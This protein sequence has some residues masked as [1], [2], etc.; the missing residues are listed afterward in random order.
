MKQRGIFRLAFIFAGVAL[1]NLPLGAQIFSGTIS[2]Y[3]DSAPPPALTFGDGLHSVTLSWSVHEVNS[4]GYFYAQSDTEVALATNVSSINQI[5]DAGIFSFTTGS[6]DSYYIGPISDVG[7]TGGLNSF[8]V[9]RSNSGFY[10]VLRI[11]DIF[12]YPV[13][14]NHGTYSSYS[15]LNATWWFQ[16][17]GS[18]NF[19]TVPEPRTTTILAALS[20]GALYLR[21]RKS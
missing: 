10:G 1:L 13:P 11:D 21:R 17:N 4:S 12:R 5:T 9:L 6:L 3:Q 19:S 7:I 2:N 20:L 8:V 15:G 14:I 18:G 16:S